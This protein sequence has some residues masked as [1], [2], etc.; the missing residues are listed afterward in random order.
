L[1]LEF[2][3]PAKPAIQADGE[4]PSSSWIPGRA[5]SSIAIPTEEQ[6]QSQIIREETLP[7]RCCERYSGKL[8]SRL[9][10]FKRSWRAYEHEAFESAGVPFASLRAGPPA[11]VGAASQHG[12][13]TRFR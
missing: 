7:V 5:T 4:G 13:L 12:L 6:Q 10:S 1:R 11:S 3:P 9:S 8:S 2:E